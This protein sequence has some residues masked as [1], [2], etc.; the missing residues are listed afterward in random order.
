MLIQLMRDNNLFGKSDQEIHQF[1]TDKYPHV[2][3]RKK[4]TDRMNKL[5]KY[6]DKER[7]QYWYDTYKK[8]KLEVAANQNEK[9][10]SE[11][12]NDVNELIE[13]VL[14][15]YRTHENKGTDKLLLLL[16]LQGACV[17]T[18]IVTV[19]CKDFNPNN[20]NYV[21]FENKRIVYNK[22]NKTKVA[23]PIII[24]DLT[25]HTWALI[26]SRKEQEYLIAGNRKDKHQF[27]SEYLPKLTTKVFGEKI[28]V[29]KFRSIFETNF[30]KNFPIQPVPAEVREAVAH[31]LAHTPETAL[32]YYDKKIVRMNSGNEDAESNDDY[33]NWGDS[34]VN[35]VETESEED[36][37][38][39]LLDSIKQNPAIQSCVI[40]FNGLRLIVTL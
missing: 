10:K 1:F 9:L 30:I 15:Y 36:K 12:I 28:G 32:T 26:N 40:E 31:R 39:Q 21:D 37:L 22:V 6:L 11:T 8:Y 35:E 25:V 5:M 23:K 19:K 4:H 13:K 33:P 3:T 34:A 2:P 27:I 17:R 18:D 38:L 16:Y 20:D 29:C 24:D 14:V 7:Y